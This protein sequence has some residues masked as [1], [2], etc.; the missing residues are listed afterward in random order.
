VFVLWGGAPWGGGVGGAWWGGGGGGGGGG[1]V[2]AK[3]NEV[4]NWY[5][6]FK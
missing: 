5:E 4:S 6:Y 2:A 1:G 3:G